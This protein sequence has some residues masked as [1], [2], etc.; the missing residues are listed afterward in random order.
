[1]S[2]QKS[3][4]K[5]VRCKNRRNK[6]NIQPTMP[7]LLGYSRSVPQ[8][9]QIHPVNGSKLMGSGGRREGYVA[10]YIRI[11]AP[12]ADTLAL[13]DKCVKRNARKRT[14][15]RAKTN[16]EE[17]KTERTPIRYRTQPV[18]ACAN[19]MFK[20]SF[21]KPAL[22]AA[23]VPNPTRRLGHAERLTAVQFPIHHAL[24]ARYAAHNPLFAGPGF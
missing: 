7:G 17:V 21:P 4:Q 5:L 11:L 24:R 15:K 8:Y 3:T 22:G 13:A 23:P 9:C 19:N 10:V 16:T 12:T 6:Q 1:M 14:P 18:P 2:P 20:H